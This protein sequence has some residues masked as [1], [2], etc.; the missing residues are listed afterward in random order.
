MVV[1][2]T[3]SSISKTEIF[4]RYNEAEILSAV[5]PEVTSLPCLICSPLR[6]DRHP[7]F[8]LY[9]SN[10]GHVYYKDHS[11]KERGSLMDLLCRY[12]G[13][14]FTHA[15]DKI[16]ELPM[17]NNVTIKPKQ[18]KMLTR[19]EYDE[20]TKIQVTVRPWRDYDYEYWGQFGITKQWQ[21]A[22]LVK[23]MGKGTSP[24]SAE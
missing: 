20:L 21:F 11:T 17:L 23:C 22:N 13:C 7:S 18:V 10:G 9:V 19:K 4:N 8:S 14:T 5:F 15:L 16:C 2:K 1:G 3:S 6:D 24:I 12:W